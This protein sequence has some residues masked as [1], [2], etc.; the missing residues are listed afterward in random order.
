MFFAFWII[1][2][3]TIKASPVFEVGAGWQKCVRVGGGGGGRG[4]GE[5]GSTE[6]RC[7]YCA[8]RP[9]YAGAASESTN[10]LKLRVELCFTQT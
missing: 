3:L 4:G 6:H 2:I 5:R 7:P 1:N 9:E 8:T 10:F